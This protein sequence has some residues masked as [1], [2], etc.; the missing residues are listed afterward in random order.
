ME[1]GFAQ[2]DVSVL[3]R[4]SKAEN[5]RDVAL[6]YVIGTPV[7][8]EINKINDVTLSECIDAAERAVGEKF[9]YRTPQAKMQAIVFAA[10]C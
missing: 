9:G 3:P 1:A 6:G 5:A 7:S 4:L 10:K 8:L 2:I